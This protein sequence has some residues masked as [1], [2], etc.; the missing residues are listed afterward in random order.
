MCRAS[1]GA[2]WPNTGLDACGIA[3]N[4]TIPAK[5]EPIKPF[6]FMGFLLEEFRE[7]ATQN[8]NCPFGFSAA[9][10]IQ[11]FV[12]GRNM[13]PRFAGEIPVLC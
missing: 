11:P 12:P 4:K 7:R 10:S 13:R 3:H 5:I 8:R 9:Q 6:R 2:A 1:A